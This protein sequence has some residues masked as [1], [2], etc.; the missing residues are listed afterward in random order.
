TNVRHSQ[1]CDREI[2]IGDFVARLGCINDLKERDAIDRHGGVVLGNHLLLWDVNYLLHHVHLAA[3][4]VDEGNNQVQSRTESMGV[5]AKAL[6]RPIVTLRNCLYPAIE[7]DND[8]EHQ[9]D[10]ENLEAAHS[11]DA[12][13]SPA[14]HCS[15]R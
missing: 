11:H 14:P 5:A 13:L 2:E 4:A 12:L 8:Q 15:V 6:Y 9:N 7:R 10:N 1:P 3:N